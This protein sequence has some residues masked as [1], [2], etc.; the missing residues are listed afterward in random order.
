MVENGWFVGQ[1]STR[2]PYFGACLEQTFWP[3]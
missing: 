2:S 3:F 1:I